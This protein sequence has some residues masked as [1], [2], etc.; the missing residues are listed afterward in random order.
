MKRFIV[1]YIIDVEKS[2]DYYFCIINGLKTKKK[3]IIWIYC[4]N[5][6]IWNYVSNIFFY[7]VYVYKLFFV[8]KTIISEIWIV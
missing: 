8:R 6:C 3:F 2:F 7:N 5:D 1:Y 4:I